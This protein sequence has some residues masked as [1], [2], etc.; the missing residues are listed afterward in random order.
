M[1]SIII[2]IVYIII[3]MK[4]KKYR[5]EKSEQWEKNIETQR[6]NF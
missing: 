6:D 2:S 4:K 3:K 5:Y 1:T